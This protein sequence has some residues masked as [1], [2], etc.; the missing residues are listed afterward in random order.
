MYEKIVFACHS[1]LSRAP[2]FQ[3][4]MAT[5]E[6]KNNIMILAEKLKESYKAARYLNR[7]CRSGLLEICSGK[8]IFTFIG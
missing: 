3:K 6:L 7:E 2:A 1:P 4:D 5:G 8:G